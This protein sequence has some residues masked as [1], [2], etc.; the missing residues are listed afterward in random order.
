MVC[1]AVE[2]RLLPLQLLLAASIYTTYTIYINHYCIVISF[3]DCA[4]R[5]CSLTQ[6][7]CYHYGCN[8]QSYS[9]IY[10]LTTK[11]SPALSQVEAEYLAQAPDV[12]GQ[13]YSSASSICF[14][15]AHD[16]SLPWLSS[17]SVCSPPSQPCPRLHP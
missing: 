8:W 16:Q 14:M 17:S 3:Q 10:I 15:E 13:A 11:Q 7:M 1:S 9:H 4:S 5:L 6:H 12:K 2:Y